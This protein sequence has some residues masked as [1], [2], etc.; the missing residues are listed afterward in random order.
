MKRTLNGG[1]TI[2]ETL[3]FLTVSA[4]IM[5][6]SMGLISGK[7]ERVRYTQTV[8]TFDQKLRDIFNDVG[9]GYY[10]NAN[11]FSCSSTAGGPIVFSGTDKEVGTNSGCTFLGKSIELGTAANATQYNTYTIVGKQTATSIADAGIQLLGVGGNPGIIDRNAIEADVQI[12]SIKSLSDPTRTVTGIAMISQFSEVTAL[13]G[14]VNGNGSRMDLY[15]VTGN[16]A[17]GFSNSSMQSST[18][19]IMLCLQ[20]GGNNG[21]RSTIKI[22]S[23][24]TTEVTVDR[25]L[26]ECT[27]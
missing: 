7:Q 26:T 6:S 17:S 8:N 21:R 19:G 16:Y 25:W 3:I 12:T 11:D 5:I 20:Q 4:A 23:N 14:E 22:N 2:I 24:L 9:T 1:Y 18:N 15:E 10:P 27:V 13:T